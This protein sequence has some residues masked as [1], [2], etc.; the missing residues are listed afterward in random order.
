MSKKFVNSIAIAFV[1]TG[2]L[3]CGSAHHSG[4]S[5]SVVPGTW[6]STPIVIDGDSK[7]WPSPYPNYDAKAM[8]AYST[9]N[10]AQNLYITMETGDEMTQMKILK[11]GMTV[12]IDT[13]GKKDPQFNI[14][15]PLQNDNEPLELVKQDHGQKS[16][17]QL[18]TRQFDQKIN[19]ILQEAN[20]FSL[21]GFTNCT[22]GFMISQTA[23]CGIKIRAR[24]DEYK[25]LVWEA[26]VPFKVLFN[27]DS[28]SATDAARTISI[29][30]AVK[31]FKPNAPKN[32]NNANSGMNNGMGGAGT[33][34]SMHGGGRGGGRGGGGN[35]NSAQDPMQHLYESTKT[36]KHFGIVFQ[37]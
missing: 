7:D 21:D 36:W 3:S 32:D 19:K 23:P 11:Q 25:E 22:G 13:N 31:G 18:V 15:Y 28:I 35:H 27:K 29:C 10:D 12:S 8:V 1:L 9:S 6:Q 2:F 20:Q 26:V 16:K 30:F 17:S 14:N 24:I 4:G 33:N 5:K 37:H 34:S